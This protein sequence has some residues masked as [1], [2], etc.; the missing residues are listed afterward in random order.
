MSVNSPAFF[1]FQSQKLQVSEEESRRT[2]KAAE[3]KRSAD[4][5]A[6]FD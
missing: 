1:L 6:A 5:S 4:A 3:G 2:A